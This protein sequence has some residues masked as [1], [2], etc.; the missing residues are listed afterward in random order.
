MPSCFQLQHSILVG[1]RSP[2]WM[3]LAHGPGQSS[4]DHQASVH[5]RK[6]PNVTCINPH[7][8]RHIGQIHAHLLI[9]FQSSFPLTFLARTEVGTTGHIHIISIKTPQNYTL[10]VT[11]SQLTNLTS[12]SSEQKVSGVHSLSALARRDSET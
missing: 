6:A 4:L 11:T 1:Q 9:Y 8:H 10:S 7:T 3:A 5:C 12:V 2:C